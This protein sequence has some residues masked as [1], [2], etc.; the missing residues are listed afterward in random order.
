VVVCSQCQLG[1]SGS[2]ARLE[3]GGSGGGWVRRGSFARAWSVA[4]SVSLDG[5]CVVYMEVPCRRSSKYSRRRR[6]VVSSITCILR[7]RQVVGDPGN[8]LRSG[9]FLSEEESMIWLSVSQE[10]A[11]VCGPRLINGQSGL[12]T[13]IPPLSAHYRFIKFAPDVAACVAVTVSWRLVAVPRQ[14]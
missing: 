11:E 13:P 1:S 14:L 2:R 7:W 5:V 6:C 10:T 3:W 9:E 4:I 12:G 8:P